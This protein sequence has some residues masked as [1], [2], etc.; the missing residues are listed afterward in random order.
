MDV[1]NKYPKHFASKF[2]A[3]LSAPQACG[4]GVNQQIHFDA[5]DYDT[6]NEYDENITY[7][8]T[9]QESGYYVF[10]ARLQFPVFAAGT[11]YSIYINT[12]AGAIN[13]QYKASIVGTAAIIEVYAQIYLLNTDVVDVYAFQVSGAPANLVIGSTGTFFEGH[14]IG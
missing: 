14:R 12:G 11:I 7:Q 3:Y 5:L 4:N 13:Q 8:F 1:S 2:H 6:L 9:P 10:H